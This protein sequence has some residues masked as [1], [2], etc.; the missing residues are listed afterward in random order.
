[1]LRADTQEEP[2]PPAPGVTTAP[3]VVGLDADHPIEQVIATA[4]DLA[5]ATGHP[6]RVVNATGVSVV[7]WTAEMLARQDDKV[8]SFLERLRHRSGRHVECKTVVANPAGALVQASQD[9]H[10]VV[11]SSGPFGSMS[12]ALLGATASQVAAHAHCPVLVLPQDQPAPTAGAVVV[13]VDADEHSAPA[14]AL[15]FAEASRR[16]APLVAVHA[17]WHDPP[18]LDT[19]T[20]E[21]I[22]PDAIANRELQMSEMLAGCRA[23]YP[24]VAVR[25]V[26]TRDRTVPALCTAAL[27]AQLLVVGTRGHGG[28]AGLL[29]GS[30]STRLIHQSPCPLLVVPS[31]PL[32]QAQPA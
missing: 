4:A 28:F 9:A 13:G 29:L 17:W 1:M 5:A 30:V 12:A 8:S 15:A 6:I 7:P 18:L 3:I 25:E 16:S 11:I 2:M 21:Q 14:V 19:A 20:W 22:E 23:E 31:R 26:L 27:D 10:V 32:P 24:D